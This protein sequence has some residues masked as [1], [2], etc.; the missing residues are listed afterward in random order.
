[1]WHSRVCTSA[2]TGVEAGSSGGSCPA[3][4]GDGAAP[5]TKIPDTPPRSCDPSVSH[6]GGASADRCPEEEE[7]SCSVATA[8]RGGRRGVAGEGRRGGVR[9]GRCQ[10][11]R[12]KCQ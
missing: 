10:T 11:G 5:G 9:E 8:S 4:V 3:A 2:T 6:P 1:M 12:R 7:E